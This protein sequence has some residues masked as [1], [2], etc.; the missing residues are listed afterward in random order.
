MF[1]QN[2]FSDDVLKV[3]EVAKRNR[4]HF[5]YAPNVGVLEEPIFKDGWWYIP[6][7]ETESTI[8]GF[9]LKRLTEVKKSGVTIKEIV[10]AHEAPPLLAVPQ[11]EKERLERLKR[12]RREKIRR[13]A[14][15][16]G[17]LIM[18]IVAVFGLAIEVAVTAM[19][20]P[21]VLIDPALII[22]L[23][24][25]TAVELVSWHDLDS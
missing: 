5:R 16:L 9:A 4:W 2:R 22:I 11:A 14:E 7:D 19:I 3:A 12:E 18:N 10:V 13:D 23:E 25:G 21:L 8:P 1:I 20:L 24:D 6:T 15:T 17:K